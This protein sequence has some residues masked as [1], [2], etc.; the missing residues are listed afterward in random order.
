VIYFWGKDWGKQKNKNS[1]A[2][3]LKLEAKMTGLVRRTAATVLLPGTAH[4]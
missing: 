3:Q 4:G 2:P 1:Q